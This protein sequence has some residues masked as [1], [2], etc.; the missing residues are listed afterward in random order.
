ME[1]LPKVGSR[2]KTNRGEKEMGRPKTDDR[3]A[4]HHDRPQSERH[5]RLHPEVFARHRA[6][7]TLVMNDFFPS[8]LL[9]LYHAF[10]GD[11]VMAIILGTI[12]HHHVRDIARRTGYDTY[13]LSKTLRMP[14]R[15]PTGL[16]PTN[17]FSVSEA[18]GIPR[19]TVRRKIGSLAA[20]SWIRRDQSGD[21]FLTP[22]PG[23]HFEHFQYQLLNDLLETVD[24]LLHGCKE[25]P[26]FKR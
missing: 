22:L 11:F 9:R 2:V 13:F 12:A 5:K 7:I 17:A 4:N 24:R 1:K 26:L 16:W 14:P 15:K 6:F 23:K 20:K 3:A 10:G 8:Y 19:E 18:T 21:L 25:M